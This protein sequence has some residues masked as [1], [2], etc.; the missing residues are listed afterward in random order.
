[1]FYNKIKVDNQFIVFVV[2]VV[3]PQMKFDQEGN[4]TTFGKRLKRNEL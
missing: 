3:F 4:V 1:M 2:V